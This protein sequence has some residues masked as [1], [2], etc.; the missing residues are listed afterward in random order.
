MPWEAWVLMSFFT[1]GLF[2]A[3]KDG[4]YEA[5]EAHKDSVYPVRG[6]AGNVL[7]AQMLGVL[8]AFMVN[9]YLLLRLGNVI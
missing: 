6:G 2:R 5:L 9:V 8:L 3:V 7:V 4:V 1:I